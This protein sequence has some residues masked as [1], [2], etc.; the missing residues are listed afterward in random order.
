MTTKAYAAIKSAQEVMAEIEKLSDA[1]THK[2]TT[3]YATVKK[4]LAMSARWNN[5][6]HDVDPGWRPPQKDA[7]APS[8]RQQAVAVGAFIQS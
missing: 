1:V 3:A 6:F 8:A 4:I 7:A 2:P 5:D